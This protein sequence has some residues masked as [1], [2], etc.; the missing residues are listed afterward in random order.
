MQISTL[1]SPFAIN[2]SYILL[3]Y[4]SSWQISVGTTRNPHFWSSLFF[5]CSSQTL[6]HWILLTNSKAYPK[7]QLVSSKQ[8]ELNSLLTISRILPARR[9]FNSPLSVWYITLLKIALRKFVTSCSIFIS[10]QRYQ[11]FR[12]RSFK[13]IFF[14]PLQVHPRLCSLK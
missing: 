9:I 5:N 8:M 3:L 4:L 14:I 13:L 1:S 11:H 10:E 7:L 12:V 2:Y 6:K